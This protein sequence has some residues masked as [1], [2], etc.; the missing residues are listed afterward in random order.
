MTIPHSNVI[1][2]AESTL[3][4]RPSAVTCAAT[5]PRYESMMMMEHKIST[6]FPKRCR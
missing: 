2:P 4:T 3:N 1:P 5:Q 6:D